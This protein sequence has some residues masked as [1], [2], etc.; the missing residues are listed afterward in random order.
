[1]RPR[2]LIYPNKQFLA[3][4]FFKI[5]LAY[6]ILQ[7]MK[8][9]FKCS[10]MCWKYFTCETRSYIDKIVG[11]GLAYILSE[12]ILLQLMVLGNNEPHQLYVKVNGSE[13]AHR[14]LVSTCVGHGKIMWSWSYK[15]IKTSFGLPDLHTILFFVR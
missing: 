6:N 11:Y 15:L 7:W 9:S 3:S 12:L 14:C 5:I 10:R 4:M 13:W 8:S 1:M 2:Y